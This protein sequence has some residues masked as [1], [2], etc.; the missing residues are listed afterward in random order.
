MI[1]NGHL[2]DAFGRQHDYLRISLTE[3]CNLRCTYCMPEDG[4]QLS[5][6][7]EIMTLDEIDGISK[8][9]V[10]MGVKTIRLTG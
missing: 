5:P 8:V 9:F 4:I 1:R 10:G 3:R 7:S 6:R 2:Q